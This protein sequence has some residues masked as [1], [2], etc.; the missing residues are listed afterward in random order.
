MISIKRTSLLFSMIY[1][2]FMFREERIGEKTIGAILMLAGFML[3]VL[4]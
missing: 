4:S 2:Y 3:I 1:G